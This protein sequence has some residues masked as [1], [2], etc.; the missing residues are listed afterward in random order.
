MLKLPDIKKKLEQGGLL[1]GANVLFDDADISE[2]FGFAGCD[3]VW[4]DM[5][6]AALD[7]KDVE[8]HIIGAHAGGSAAFVRLP[9]NDMVMA[10][11]ILDMG[12]DGVIIPL[13]RSAEDAINA[14]K[15]CS[16]P[17]K[18]VRGWN[19]IRATKYGCMDAGW[20]ISHVDSL[21]WKIVMI[22]HID[23]VNDL[24]NILAIPDIDAIMIGPS[25]LTGSIGHLLETDTQEFWNLID[26]ITRAAKEAGKVIGVAL[27]VNTSKE[28]I[29]KWVSYGVQ[30]VSIGQDANFLVRIVQ[31]NVRT[32]REAHAE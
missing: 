26:R 29:R 25:D 4:I 3:Y 1:V 17:P 9:W 30:M 8:R 32:A 27:P 7:Y 16:Y 6:H 14:V 31:D 5:E 2:L 18:G 24:E 15:Y 20:Y 28:L 21:T 10:K 13:I 11:R 22:E 19:P 23:A 12:P